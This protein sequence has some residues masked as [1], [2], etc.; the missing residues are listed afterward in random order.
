MSRTSRAR[1]T[2]VDTEAPHG[3][4]SF[5]EEVERGLTAPRKTLPCRFLYDEAG[6]E[7]FEEICALPEYYVT[8]AEREILESSS[9]QIAARFSSPLTLAEL[10][11]GSSAKTRLLIEAFLRRLGGLRYVPV[12]ISRSMLEESSLALLGRYEGLEIRAI[13]SEY[14]EGLRQVRAETGRQKLIAWLGSNI[15]NFERGAASQFLRSMREALAHEDRLLVGI[16]LRKDRGVLERAYDDAQGVTA[17]FNLNLLERINRE[18]GGDFRVGDFAHRA[19][20]DEVEGRVSMFLESRRR[21]TAS[22]EDLGLQVEFRAGERI[23]TE[24]SH[25]YD[26]EEIDALTASAGLRVEC[27]WLDSGGRFSLNLLAPSSPR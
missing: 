6:S 18:L 20:Y 23:H 17:R 4:A 7:L 25:K 12:D 24:N 5:A 3:D 14:R 19:V 21:Q 1:Y 10:G 2:L 16:D 9:D 13:A 11:S 15:G 27:R 26:V 22:I 8:R